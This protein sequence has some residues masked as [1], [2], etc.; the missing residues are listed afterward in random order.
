MRKTVDERKAEMV[1]EVKAAREWGE[2]HEKELDPVIKTD[3]WYEQATRAGVR[4]RRLLY[5]GMFAEEDQTVVYD[6]GGRFLPLISEPKEIDLQQTAH[7]KRIQRAL[8]TLPTKQ[9]ELLEAYALEG[10][11]LNELRTHGESKQA[12]HERLA[13]ARNAFAKAI[14]ATAEE[15]VILTGDDLE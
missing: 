11:T 9:R 12:V 3:S 1:A 2:Q 15:P 7:N 4:Y 10:K 13:W 5:L 14:L 8:D 6:E